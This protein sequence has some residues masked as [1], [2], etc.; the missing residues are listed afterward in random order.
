MERES[1]MSL[2]E[3]VTMPDMTKTFFWGRCG[4]QSHTLRLRVYT[5]TTAH[6]TDSNSVIELCL[7]SECRCGGHPLGVDSTH[8][9]AHAV[10]NNADHWITFQDGVI[11]VNREL[12]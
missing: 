2:T 7:F 8:T 9:L 5:H 11:R 6:A 1:A 10:L 4:R 3:S 12:S